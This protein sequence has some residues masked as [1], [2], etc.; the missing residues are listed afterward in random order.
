MRSTIGGFR[1]SRQHGLPAIQ[2][3]VVTP[4]LLARRCVARLTKHKKLMLVCTIEWHAA[5]RAA[6]FLQATSS[7][8][9]YDSSQYSAALVAIARQF[10]TIERCRRALAHRRD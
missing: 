1:A 7:G 6:C 5:L 3:A 10:A 9:Y 2:N 4:S 8:I